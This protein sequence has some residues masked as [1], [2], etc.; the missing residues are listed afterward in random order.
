MRLL[1]VLLAL[2]LPLAALAQSSGFNPGGRWS[3]R[4]VALEKGRPVCSETWTFGADGTMSV[5]SG[6]ERVQKRYRIEEDRDG[7]W[8]VTET[9]ST[10]HQ[11]DCMGNVTTAIEPGEHR[12]FIL[13]TNSGVVLTCPPPQ[14]TADGIPM[15][16]ECYGS[17]TQM[18]PSG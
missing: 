18:P 4:T 8:I 6:A 16:R 17:L 3:F 14:H 1:T 2:C 15:I 12:T 13:R 7:T 10:N 5:E 11:P 9:L